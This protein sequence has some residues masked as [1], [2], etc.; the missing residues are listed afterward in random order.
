MPSLGHYYLGERAQGL[1]WL[2]FWLTPLLAAVWAYLALPS[3]FLDLTPLFWTAGM[4][5]HGLAILSVARPKF[6][7]Q[8]TL[9][10]LALSLILLGA[11]FALYLTLGLVIQSWLTIKDPMKFLWRAD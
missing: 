5:I 10:A 7:C 4:L 9:G 11:V 3:L 6:Y 8:S 2:A 1:R